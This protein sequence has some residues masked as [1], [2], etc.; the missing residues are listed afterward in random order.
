MLGEGYEVVNFAISGRTML[1]KGDHPFMAEENYAK[2][3]AYLPDI[4]TIMLGTNDAKPKNWKY[5]EEFI[6]DLRTM[7]KEFKA[8]PSH[9]TIYLCLPPWVYSEMGGITE[10]CITEEVIPAIQQVAAE[11]W[12]EVIDTHSPLIEHPEMFADGVHPNAQGAR[13]LAET[14]FK[15]FEVCGDTGKQG[16]RVMFIGDSITDGDWGKDDGKP[17]LERNPY[18]RNHVYGHGYQADVAIHFLSDYPE[19]RFKF[20][21]RGIS[22]DRLPGLVARWDDDVLAVHP[23]IISIYI[24]INDTG[25][26]GFSPENWEAQYRNILDRSLAFDPE[27]KFVLCIPL[28]ENVGYVKA[29]G[30]YEIRRKQLDAE[31]E[32]IFR[33]AKEYDAV[34]VPFDEVIA[35][36]IRTDKSGSCKH[37]IWDGIHPTMP[38]HAKMAQE[39][40][41]RTKQLMK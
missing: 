11:S 2:A 17:C 30:C 13:V 5:K 31:K 6:N 25:G 23:D 27:V 33:L 10:Q 39:W 7:V 12:L 34:V 41:K 16:K 19:K 28:V 32:I 1:N 36:C 35:E 20:Y 37:W 24:G 21:N 38:G 9:P 3:K 29:T 26:P 15:G 14:V 18:D 40:I 4:V 8:I 22:G